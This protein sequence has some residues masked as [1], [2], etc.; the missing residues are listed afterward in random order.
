M[1]SDR[2]AKWLEERGL[3]AEKASEEGVRS[4]GP[5]IAFPYVKNG[6]ELYSKMRNLA[7]K[8]RTFCEPSGVPQLVLWGEDALSEKT[9]SDD[10][11]IIVEGEPDRLAALQAGYQFVVSVPSG[12]A[13]TI[14]GNR[15]KAVRCLA[16]DGDEEKGLKPSIAAFAR[17]IVATDGDN[18]GNMLR[19]AICELI[20]RE[21]CWVVTYPD[22]CKDANDILRVRTQANV[23]AEVAVHNAAHPDKPMTAVYG[24]EAV[25]AM[26]EG[27]QP[28][29]SDGFVAFTDVDR[30][31]RTGVMEIGIE[32]LTPYLKLG[33]PEFLVIGGE[34]NSGKSTVVQS[35]LFNLLWTNPTLKASI[36][37]GE[38]AK[39][40]P[41]TRARR[42]FGYAMHQRRGGSAEQK[43]ARDA[44]MDERLAFV[45]P[46]ADALPTFEWLLG[47]MERQALYRGRNVFVI[48]P[49]NEIILQAPK[50]VNKTDWIAECIIKMKRLA[51][52][53]KLIMIVAHHVTKARDQY[54]PPD[55]YSLADSAHWANKSD[56]VLMVWKPK[57]TTNKTLLIVDKSKDYERL[58][59]LGS[60]WVALDVERF[61]L[62]PTSSPEEDR[63]QAVDLKRPL[64]DPQPQRAPD[65][66]TGKT[67]NP[68][69]PKRAGTP[70]H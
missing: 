61:E 36:F 25:R 17:V 4:E 52:R 10:T 18:D 46:P 35:I 45:S 24:A 48:D 63:K 47:A 59:K 39:D 56:H 15:S 2:H 23:E 65:G 60:Q 27:A 32:C 44:F 11:L 3:D 41:V 38:G 69:Q 49:W 64:S 34:A 54:G 5:Y 43:A 42:F 16:I 37:H 51:D 8:R 29:V 66:D 19:D 1:L 13:N 62:G 22:G 40:I 12:A 33:T 20:G 58:G 67:A 14:E 68:R 21:F 6:R 26:I 53:L 70:V 31:P 55:K 28:V 30:M 50:G 7:D 57:G 9:P